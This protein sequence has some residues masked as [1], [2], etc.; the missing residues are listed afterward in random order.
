VNRKTDKKIRADLERIHEWAG[1]KI[2]AGNEPPW[3]WYQ[4]MKLRETIDAILD[5]MSVVSPTAGSPQSDQRQGSGLRLA[6]C[7]DSQEI[8]RRRLRGTPVRLPT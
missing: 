2:G 8:A 1:D 4:Y 3:A 5:G 6:V 7:N